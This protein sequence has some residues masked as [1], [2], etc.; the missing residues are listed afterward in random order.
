MDDQWIDKDAALISPDAKFRHDLALAL[1]NSHERQRVQRQLYGDALA[2]KRGRTIF[3]RLLGAL[4][5]LTLVFGLGFY[6]GQQSHKLRGYA[7]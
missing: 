5:L 7:G 3:W 1:Q 4:G 2:A 6:V